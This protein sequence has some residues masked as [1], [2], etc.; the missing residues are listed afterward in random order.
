MSKK[1]LFKIGHL[2][3]TLG[4][5]HRT[6][7]YYDQ[8]GLL[9]HMKR[10]NGGVR[11]FDDE[12]IK[13]LKKIRTLQ[14][15]EYLPLDII[16]KKLFNQKSSTKIALVSDNGAIFGEKTSS[17][18]FIPCFAPSEN[19][20]EIDPKG[21]KS[22]IKKTYLTLLEEG[23]KKIYSIHTGTTFSPI[24][25]L[26]KEVQ[27]TIT[28]NDSI[29]IIDS[30]SVGC[31]LGLFV[32]EVN[33]AIENKENT[34]NIDLL[35]K[36]LTPLIY[37]I[38]FLEVNNAFFNKNLNNS[39]INAQFFGEFSQFMPVFTSSIHDPLNVQSLC[40]NTKQSLDTLKETL[41]EEIEARGNYYR[42][43]RILYYYFYSEATDIVNELQN[44]FPTLSVDLIKA[45]YPFITNIGKK[46][47]TV[48][49]I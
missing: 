33:A 15:E 19:S 49:I 18:H 35:I 46:A 23:Y 5:T 12:D 17:A 45:D 31:G 4:L 7:R 44:R 9:P 1:K 29:E 42:K 27:E 40:R 41:I 48:S 28:H 36:K 39:Q 22:K 21:I 32:E 25:N 14:K 43:A 34:T 37:Q 16:K 24:I 20:I 6:I 47:L 13:I 3:K 26:A 10:S 11:L 30:N 38:G 2:A 8:L